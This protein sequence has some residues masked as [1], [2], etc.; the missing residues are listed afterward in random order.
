TSSPSTSGISTSSNTTSEYL[1][2]QVVFNIRLI[3]VL[4][5]LNS[6]WMLYI[7]NGMNRLRTLLK[8]ISF[9]LSKRRSRNADLSD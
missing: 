5:L 3:V 1:L 9:N 6:F 4:L 8:E 2:A 7:F